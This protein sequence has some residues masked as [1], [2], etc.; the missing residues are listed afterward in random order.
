[1]RLMR[2]SSSAREGVLIARDAANHAVCF[3]VM[4]SD[5]RALG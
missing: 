2:M 1:M 3:F 5:K 4:L